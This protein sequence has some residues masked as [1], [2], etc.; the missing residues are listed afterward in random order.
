LF[1]GEAI[2]EQASDSTEESPDSEGNSSDPLGWKSFDMRS[3]VNA[4]EDL[5]LFILSEKGGRVRVFLLRDVIKAAD[6]FLQDEV[7]GVLNEKPEAREASD[8]EVC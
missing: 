7:A 6:V 8:S 4:T 5:L 3:V 2:S 1:Q